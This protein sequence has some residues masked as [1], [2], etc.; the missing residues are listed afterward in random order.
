MS[1]TVTIEG[2]SCGHCAAHVE[3]ALRGIGLTASVDLK[4]KI[5]TITSGDASDEAIKQAVEDEGYEV[6]KIV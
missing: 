1:K 2:M 4:K 5:A 6:V 3:Q